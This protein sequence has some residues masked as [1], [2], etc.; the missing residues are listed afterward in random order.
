MFTNSRRDVGRY[1]Q[2]L[3]A[4]RSVADFLADEVTPGINSMGSEPPLDILYSP[5]GGK[6]TVVMFHAAARP[7]S[8][9]PIFAGGNVAAD[10]GVNRIHVSDP[11]LCAGDGVRIA[12]F[13]GTEQLPL[14]RVL[15]DVLKKLI[16]DAGGERTVFW[17]PSAGGFA[18]LYYSRF[19]ANSLAMPVNPQTILA[20]F[21]YANQRSY[22]KAAFGAESPEQHDEVLTGRICSDL[23]QHYAGET[24]NYVYYVQN[25][26]DSHVEYH[27]K[28]FLESLRPSA[29]V[30]THLSDNWGVGH[31][32][33]QVTELRTILSSM[34]DPAVDWASHF[35][36]R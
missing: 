2:P 11:G 9:L 4:H 24:P 28:P 21:G 16:D 34:T 22:T 17:G 20:N 7:Q 18:A 25:L 3:I 30:R 8:P 33:P 15:P 29:R 5:T 14:Q 10:H 12:W 36:S 1:K 35:D 6:T 32:A 27:M 26:L 13:A 19:F 23:R 31:V